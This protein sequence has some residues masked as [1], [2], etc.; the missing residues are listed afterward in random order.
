MT[1]LERFLGHA[2]PIAGELAA[3]PACEHGPAFV[4]LFTADLPA[5]A[6]ALAADLRGLHSETASGSF[7]LHAGTGEEA[8]LG[9]AG[10]GPHVVQL[11]GYAEPAPTELLERCVHPSPLRHELK[12]QAAGHRTHAILVYK[13]H[14]R[15][16]LEQHVALAAV[17]SVLATA[18]ASTVINEAGRTAFPAVA[19]RT[20]GEGL[21]TLRFL[22]DLPLLMLYAGFVRYEVPGLRGV[23]MR[24]RGCPALGLPDLAFRAASHEQGEEVFDLF[25]EVLG[26][27][28]ESGKSL[29]VGHTM[30][31]G[32]D[33]FLTLRA[34]TELEYFLDSPGELFVA[35]VADPDEVFR[36]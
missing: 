4:V 22:H 23:W 29:G 10:W 28:R 27:L 11:L 8:L 18:G 24:T 15:D 30:Q 1:F 2:P 21:D 13:G 3:D 19:L 9:L 35:E 14:S 20:D 32:A 5:D 16:P 26:Y 31:M 25:T 33:L 12:L 6:T 7:E 36:Q 34:P 17:A